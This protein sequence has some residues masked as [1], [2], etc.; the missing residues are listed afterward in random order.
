MLSFVPVAVES[1]ANDGDRFELAARL[2]G[3]LKA[4]RRE[5]DQKLQ[6]AKNGR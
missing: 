5:Y 4:L 1:P 2:F 6:A 3:R